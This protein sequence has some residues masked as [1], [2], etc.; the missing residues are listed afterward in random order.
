MSTK[1]PWLWVFIGMALG[2]ALFGAGMYV[3]AI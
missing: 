3:G 1:S 2:A